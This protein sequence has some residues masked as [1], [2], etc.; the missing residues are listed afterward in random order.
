VRAGKKGTKNG[1]REQSKHE[2]PMVSTR[3]AWEKR[4]RRRGSGKTL[5]SQRV[6]DRG[7]RIK[8]PKGRK[9]GRP[10]YRLCRTKSWDTEVVNSQYGIVLEK[11]PS[12]LTATQCEKRGMGSLRGEAKKKLV[13]SIGRTVVLELQRPPRPA[14]E[15]HRKRW[16]KK[17]RGRSNRREVFRG[18]IRGENSGIHLEKGRALHWPRRCSNTKIT[19]GT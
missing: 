14:P 18:R 12:G 5:T 6:I 11:I 7:H 17:K 16:G 1:G 15:L 19:A 9:Q 2:R 3:N 8:S 10:R 4:A 13:R